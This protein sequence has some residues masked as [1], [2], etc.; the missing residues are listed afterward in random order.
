MNQGVMVD[1][2]R[3]SVEDDLRWK[4]TFGGRQTSLEGDLLWKTTFC[5]RRPSLEDNLQ[6]K[7]TFSGRQP[8]MEDNLRWSFIVLEMVKPHV[9]S[10]SNVENL[11]KCWQ[12]TFRMFWFFYE[13]HAMLFL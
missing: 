10:Y 12:L 9:S 7:T 13:E 11:G 1:G 2:R 6:W 4:T 5:E 3:L 8:S